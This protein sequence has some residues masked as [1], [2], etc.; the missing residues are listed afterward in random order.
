MICIL[1][2][3]LLKYVLKVQMTISDDKRRFEA[4]PLPE[5]MLIQFT[6]VNMRH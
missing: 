4:K 5:P 6:D 1:I 3:I 2:K